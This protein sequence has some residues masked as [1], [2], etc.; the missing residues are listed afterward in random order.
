[1]SRLARF[2]PLVLRPLRRRPAATLLTLGGIA[3]ATFLLVAVRAIDA[4][5]RESTV[6][7]PDDR[8]LIV[9]RANRFCPFTSRLPQHYTARIAAIPG[10]ESAIP[11]LAEVTI[12]M[13]CRIT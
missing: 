9:Y 13:P 12:S 8:T 3:I 2:I 4:G 1:M 10:V 5:V 7:G 6:A 11:M